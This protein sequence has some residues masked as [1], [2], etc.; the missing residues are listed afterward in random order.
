MSI[1]ASRNIFADFGDEDK[2]ILNRLW[3]MLGSLEI[4]AGF[5]IDEA[6]IESSKEK[7]KVSTI[8]DNRLTVLPNIEYSMLLAVLV[9]LKS[10][11]DEKRSIKWQ[12]VNLNLEKHSAA[13]ANEENIIYFFKVD[14][15]N[16]F[17]ALAALTVFGSLI[18]K[19][20]WPDSWRLDD[21]TKN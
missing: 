13:R 19:Y 6:I 8:D 2:K 3:Q 12:I 10:R 5:G 7:L 9:N 16:P 18:I 20:Y 11:H 15:S 14:Y 1:G 21:K 4:D 17:I